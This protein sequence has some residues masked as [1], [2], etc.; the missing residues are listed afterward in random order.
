M[1]VLDLQ[2]YLQYDSLAGQLVV[3][4]QLFHFLEQLVVLQDFLVED[5]EVHA[6]LQTMLLLHYILLG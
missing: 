1:I 6:L 5:E 2:T 4:H 3:P